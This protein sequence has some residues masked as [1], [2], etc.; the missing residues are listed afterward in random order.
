VRENK[1]KRM[2]RE[3]RLAVGVS[4]PFY[5]AE[6]VEFIGLLGFDFVFI[7]GEHGPLTPA[8]AQPMILAAELTGIE[9][10]VRVPSPDAWVILSY[11][12]VGALTVQVPHVNTP[13]IAKQVVDAVKYPPVGNRGAGSTTRAARYGLRLGAA[14]YFA[15]ANDQTLAIPMIEEPTAVENAEEIVKVPG[16]EAIFIGSGDLALTMGLPGQRSHPEVLAAINRTRDAAI[17]AGVPVGGVGGS[18]AANNDLIKEGYAF[19]LNSSGALFAGACKSF[20]EG[21][22]R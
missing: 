22:Q 15:A 17:K 21:I 9:P 11:L 20:L 18:S 5:T 13:E 4:S 7:D 19:S 8:V 12:E 2:F 16:L 14:E 3:G 10:V 1:L 6:A